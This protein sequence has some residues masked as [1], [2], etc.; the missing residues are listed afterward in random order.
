M[1]DHLL[2]KYDSASPDTL[3]IGGAQQVWVEVEPGIEMW[4]VTCNIHAPA[5][6]SK[7][8]VAFPFP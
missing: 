6:D 3:R 4:V 5:D 8:R 1:E 7:G 2:Y